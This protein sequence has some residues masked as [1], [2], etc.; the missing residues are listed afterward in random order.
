[1]FATSP[2]GERATGSKAEDSALTG[3]EPQ[4]RREADGEGSENPRG[5]GICIFGLKI[6][7]TLDQW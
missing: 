4:L 6:P 1:M 3:E 2:L 5:Q 7:K